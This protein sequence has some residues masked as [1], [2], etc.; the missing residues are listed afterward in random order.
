[1][2]FLYTWVIVSVVMVIIWSYF[3]DVS[4]FGL[5]I[6][7][8]SRII[9]IWHKSAYSFCFTY[10]NIYFFFFL[11]FLLQNFYILIPISYSYTSLSFSY[12]YPFVLLLYIL[13]MLFKSVLHII[14]L[15]FP[16]NYLS[17]TERLVFSVLII[18][19]DL[20]YVLFTMLTSKS[21]SLLP[22]LAFSA[23]CLFRE[24]SY[25]IPIWEWESPDMSSCIQ[26]I[27]F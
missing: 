4:I 12:F 21:S 16:Q 7:M 6:I 20:Y 5:W 22:C 24:A 11:V 8:V 17:S 18:S 13:G 25:F 3:Q 9:V 26:M 23:Y 15:I 1:M 2:W 19:T 14:D 10:E 27:L